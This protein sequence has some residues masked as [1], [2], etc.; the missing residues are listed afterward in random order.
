MQ[1]AV[2]PPVM[3]NQMVDKAPPRTI[4]VRWLVAL[5]GVMAAMQLSMALGRSINWDEFW[6]YSQVEVVARG[7]F[8]QPLQ[9]IHTRVFF[10]L[11]RMGGSEIDHILIARLVMWVCALVT[12]GGIYLLAE[13]FSDKRTALLA[14]A[15]YMGAGFVLQHSTAFRVDPIVTTLLTMALVVAARSR[16]STAWIAVLG[17]LIGLA[18]M[19]TIKFVLWAPAFF[20]IALWKWHDEGYDWRYIARWFAAGAVSLSVFALLYWLHS[21]DMSPSQISGSAEATLTASADR[22]FH[23]FGSPHGDV[24]FKGF[25]TALPLVIAAALLPWALTQSEQPIAKKLGI[26]GLWAMLLTPAYYFNAYPYF[27]PFILPPVAVA[28]AISIPLFTKRYGQL[29][30]AALTLLSAAG[31]WMVDARGVTER[32]QSLVAAVHEVFPEPVNYIDCCGMIG[33]FNKVNEF[34]TQWG[35][36]LY[37]QSGR[38]LILET[39]SEQ[40]VPLLIDNNR[41]F[42]RA[43]DGS[44]TTTFHAS[45]IEAMR[46]TYIRHWGDIFVAGRDIAPGETLAWNVLVPGTYTVDAGPIFIDGRSYETGSQIELAR[47]QISLGNDAS[48]SARLIWGKGLKRPLADPPEQYWTSF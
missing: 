42:S 41:E 39:L 24:A 46:E 32:Q 18:A 3:G 27:F 14:V 28:C 19:V 4:P 15:A 33:S 16:L 38:P 48:Q 8:I 5:I 37:Q 23:F 25:A 45:D 40:T 12:A 29:T 36:A 2:A 30:F 34:R 22:M 43:M 31:I 26:L 21:S 10:W 6:F 7:E 13:K 47:G 1:S 11:P 44:D 20:G 17:A 9:T 35:V